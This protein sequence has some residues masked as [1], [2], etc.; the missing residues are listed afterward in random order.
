MNCKTLKTLL[1]D[2]NGFPQEVDNT[3]KHD[4]FVMKLL[5]KIVSHAYVSKRSWYDYTPVCSECNAVL[6]QKAKMRLKNGNI[7]VV[8]RKF[9]NTH[10]A[11]V[12]GKHTK[13]C[14]F[15]M[16]LDILLI[17]GEL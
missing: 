17:H 14:K 4:E 6:L 1:A 13:T 15:A 9:R 5:R 12:Q 8:T 11:M 2:R 7:K 3:D 16:A 10:E